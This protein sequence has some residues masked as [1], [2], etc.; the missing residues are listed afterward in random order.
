M[1]K[2]SSKTCLI[3]AGLLAAALPTCAEAEGWRYYQPSPR[4]K[5]TT[6]ETDARP[7]EL[8]PLTLSCENFILKVA[9]LIRDPKGLKEPFSFRIESAQQIAIVTGKLLKGDAG[10]F[11]S[12]ELP[13]GDRI[14]PLL[15]KGGFQI[16]DGNGV[17]LGYIKQSNP[18]LTDLVYNCRK[19]S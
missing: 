11:I 13:F 7:G 8:G 9:V 15:E 6:Y 3:V 2:I 1:T 5:F 17:V 4:N 14:F 19:G 16:R 18:Y 10:Y 12:T